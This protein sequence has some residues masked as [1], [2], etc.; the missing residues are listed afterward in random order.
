MPKKTQGQVAKQ[1]EAKMQAFLTEFEALTKPLY[2][3]HL[4]RII[5]RVVNLSTEVKVHYEAA[6]AVQRFTK[7][8]VTPVSNETLASKPEADKS[9][10]RDD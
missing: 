7:E 9:T 3:K 2:D 10:D 1:D 5:P 4:M 8:E 6:F